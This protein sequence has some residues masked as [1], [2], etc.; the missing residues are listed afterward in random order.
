MPL[1]DR[2]ERGHVRRPAVQMGGKNRTREGRD[3][4]FDALGV[5]VVQLSGGFP[6]ESLGLRI[7]GS[8]QR[9]AGE[10]EGGDR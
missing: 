7:S 5:E 10:N 3:R 2:L 1:G 9:E 6:A 8:A 4:V